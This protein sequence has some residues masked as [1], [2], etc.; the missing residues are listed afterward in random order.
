M[1]VIHSITLIKH[2]SFSEF[3]DELYILAE[4]K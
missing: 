4:K 1:K 3:H 2:P